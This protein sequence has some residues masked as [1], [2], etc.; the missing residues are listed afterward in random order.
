MPRPESVDLR[1]RLTR[2]DARL[3][4]AG[5]TWGYPYPSSGAGFSSTGGSYIE[6]GRPP[7]HPGR[8]RGRNLQGRTL[9]KVRRAERAVTAST[10]P[11]HTA[12]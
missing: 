8:V 5:R 4:L 3:A 9:Q 6:R 11:L 10:R 2:A 1:D 12:T 7:I